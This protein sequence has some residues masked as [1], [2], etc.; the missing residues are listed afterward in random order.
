MWRIDW[1][2]QEGKRSQPP[3]GRQGCRYCRAQV[4]G[5]GDQ[6]VGVGVVWSRQAGFEVHLKVELPGLVSELSVGVNMGFFLSIWV[7]RGAFN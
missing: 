2:G 3:V 7:N 5:G 4:R 1:K 6:A